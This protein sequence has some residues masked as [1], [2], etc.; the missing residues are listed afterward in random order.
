METVIA[1]CD[2]QNDHLEHLATHLTTL[3]PPEP[4]Q[5]VIDTGTSIEKDIGTSIE[6]DTQELDADE[7]QA[8]SNIHQPAPCNRN[9]TGKRKK[10]IP[11]RWHHI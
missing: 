3:N 10:P 1:T 8:P 9:H 7:N 4:E 11:R 5:P 6:E 2:S